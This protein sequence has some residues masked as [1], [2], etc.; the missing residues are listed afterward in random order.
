MALD[1]ALFPGYR[2][3]SRFLRRTAPR[4]AMTSIATAGRMERRKPGGCVMA[5]EQPAEPSME[6]PSQFHL[7]LSRLAGRFIGT[8][9][10]YPMPGFP[11]VQHA[12]ATVV[13]KLEL[14]GLLLLRNYETRRGS[15][16]IYRGHG[17]YTWDHAHK[18]YAVYWFDTAGTS[19][20]G[21]AFG[22]W[23]D[24]ALDFRYYR[25]PQEFR[26]LYNFESDDKYLFSVEKLL[27]ATSWEPALSGIYTRVN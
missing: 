18:S 21:P 24:D 1:T 25:G 12:E 16:I 6:Q 19:P 27:D 7:Q 2:E 13:G 3:G 17:V 22:T 15:E 5:M 4:G 20:V 26:L 9:T 14:N 10:H 11:Q 23:I 8:E